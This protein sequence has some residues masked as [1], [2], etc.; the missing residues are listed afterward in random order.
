MECYNPRIDQWHFAPSM[1]QRRAGCGV[2]VYDG[3]LYVAGKDR[4]RNYFN[5]TSPEVDI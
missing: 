5:T 3:K 1:K 4:D 2:A